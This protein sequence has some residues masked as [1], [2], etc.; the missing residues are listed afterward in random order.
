MVGTVTGIEQPAPRANRTVDRFPRVGVR[1]VFP[2]GELA[3]RGPVSPFTGPGVPVA[4]PSI[5]PLQIGEVR[6]G[7]GVIR[8][9]LV[10][11]PSGS[12]FSP[13]NEISYRGMKLCRYSAAF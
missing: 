10:L 2:A 13:H 4:A 11:S 9:Q 6:L 3:V 1:I 5:I 7:V 12:G 8:S